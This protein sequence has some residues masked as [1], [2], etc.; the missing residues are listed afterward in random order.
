MAVFTAFLIFF[1]STLG[2]LSSGHGAAIPGHSHVMDGSGMPVGNGDG[3][4]GT[5][6]GDGTGG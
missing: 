3:G 4:S 1:G 2:L 5:D 6:G